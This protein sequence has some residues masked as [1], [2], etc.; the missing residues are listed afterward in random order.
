MTERNDLEILASFD[1]R[2]AGIEH[3]VPD[4][5]AWSARRVRGSTRAVGLPL[6][7]RL[8]LT[9]G[10]VVVAIALLAVIPGLAGLAG[11]TPSTA[12]PALGSSQSLSPSPS[13]STS[14][15]PAPAIVLGPNGLPTSLGDEPVLSVPAGLSHA[16]VA[17]DATPFLVAGWL[18]DDK[19]ACPPIPGPVPTPI[20]LD[21]GLC[22]AWPALVGAPP[23]D[24][25]GQ[26]N[27]NWSSTSVLWTVFLPG[28]SPLEPAPP[29]GLGS[30]NLAVVLR[31]HTHDPSASSCAVDLQSQCEA[32]VVVNSVEWLSTSSS[33]S[34]SAS[35]DFVCIPN[36]ISLNGASPIPTPCSTAAWN[37]VLQAVGNLGYPVKAVTIGLFRFS[38]DGPF[39]MDPISC[40]PVPFPPPGAYVQFVGTDKVAALTF[41]TKAGPVTATVVAFEVPPSGWS[42]GRD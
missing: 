35:I 16:F 2:L 18:D 6:S 19:A 7:S 39:G 9:A 30:R 5:A 41:G 8:G 20:L 1:R 14:P 38:C 12:S 31:V 25:I 10:A 3:E 34:P 42:I 32:A 36:S 11:R 4:P 26:P 33:P 29:S 37:A 21:T 28:S 24:S 22:G 40:P 17:S 13:Q 23:Y 15:L 27:F